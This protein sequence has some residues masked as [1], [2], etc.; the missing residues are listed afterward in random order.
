M[1]RKPTLVEIDVAAHAAQRTT[2]TIR[3]WIRNGRLTRYPH[4]TDRRRALVDL[5]QVYKLKG[6][7]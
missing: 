7:R 2:A 4:P 3:D 6:S 1:T 5:A